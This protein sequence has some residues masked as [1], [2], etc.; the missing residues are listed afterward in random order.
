[1][2][3]TAAMP[4][5]Q[6]G[7]GGNVHISTA[8]YFGSPSQHV[9][10]PEALAVIQRQF[11]SI[12]PSPTYTQ[13]MSPHS[14]FSSPTDTTMSST[15][16]Q[17]LS[18]HFHPP[19]P[20]IGV[21]PDTAAI[22]AHLEL[23]NLNITGLREDMQKSQQDYQAKLFQ[24]DEK[25]VSKHTDLQTKMVA[26]EE[27]LALSDVTTYNKTESSNK[28]EICKMAKIVQQQQAT[29]KTLLATV[30]ANQ[31]TAKKDYNELL[32][33]VNSVEG[34]QRRWAVR[35][36]GVEA[37]GARVETTHETKLRVVDFITKE[38][39]IEGV[40]YEDVDTAHRVGIKD[41]NGKQT[42]LT[43]FY[44][45]DITQKLLKNKRVLKG[46]DYVL[47]EDLT[48]K[49]RTLL[50]NVKHHSHVEAAWSQNGSIWTIL[51]TGG[52]KFK[53]KI[54]DDLEEKLR[55]PTIIAP[56]VPVV[57]PTQPIQQTDEPPQPAQHLN[58]PVYGPANRPE[59]EAAAAPLT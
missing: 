35:I 9:L 22:T 48:L 13:T 59:Q 2:S 18:S 51:K 3:Q 30:E 11:T 25:M 12:T 36:F 19:L 10:S 23:L 45:R 27:K 40:H 56:A 42:V 54:T 6:N 39:K 14:S 26:L 46:S 7:G 44:S 8:D 21:N 52:R 50:Y 29:I 32:E 38:L 49:S 5:S 34:H 37:P 57:D 31:L 41:I 15:L 43:R 53:V 33:L 4:A 58:G 24:L 28:S 55:L 1:M 17:S 20:A 16:S 47:H